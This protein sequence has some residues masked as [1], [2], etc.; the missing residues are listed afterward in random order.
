[1]ASTNATY[2]IPVGHSHGLQTIGS[3]SHA[4]DVM[5]VHNPH[6]YGAVDRFTLVGMIANRL[7]LAPG[8]PMP[9]ES[10]H[11]HQVACDKILVFVVQGGEPVIITEGDLFPSDKLIT[12]LRLL[13]TPNTTNKYRVTP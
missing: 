10:I 3:H 5:E 12:Q 2:P 4:M 9:F 6:T 1:M 7:R 13:M 8:E 11:C